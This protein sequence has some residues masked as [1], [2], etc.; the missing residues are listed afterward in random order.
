MLVSLIGMARRTESLDCL[1]PSEA[2]F[3]EE[4]DSECAGVLDRL[5]IPIL[6]AKDGAQFA[7]C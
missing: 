5:E 2:G 6:A 7:I 1:L 4:G 3:N